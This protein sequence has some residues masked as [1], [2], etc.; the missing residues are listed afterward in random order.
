[1]LTGKGYGDL[2]QEA[3]PEAVRVFRENAKQ[4]PKAILEK[5]HPALKN[6]RR[7]AAAIAQ[8]DR[9]QQRV[10]FAGIGNI[11]GVVV[12]D[13]QTRSLVSYNGTVG[14]LTSS[15]TIRH[16]DSKN[17][18]LNLSASTAVASTLKEIWS[19]ARSTD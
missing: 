2:A 1:L 3:S 4:G 14:H 9:T 18:F 15:P 16:G 13:R 11:S 12:T 6:T 7:A 8:I 19:Y 5:A 10:S 17:H